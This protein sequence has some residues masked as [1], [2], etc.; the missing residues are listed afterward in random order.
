MA[1]G[2]GEGMSLESLVGSLRPLPGGAQGLLVRKFL[3]GVGQ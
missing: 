3:K 1:A 2:T